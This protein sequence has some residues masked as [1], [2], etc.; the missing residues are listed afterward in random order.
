MPRRFLDKN[1]KVCWR[2]SVGLDA[3]ALEGL[4]PG[5]LF[6]RGPGRQVPRL[7]LVDVDRDALEMDLGANWRIA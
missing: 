2:D 5:I 3:A 6:L 4:A 7:D 1:P